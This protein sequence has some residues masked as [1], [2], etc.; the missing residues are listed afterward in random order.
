MI[1]LAV[2]MAEIGQ[3][4]PHA[5]LPDMTRCTVR[6]EYNTG[7]FEVTIDYPIA[8]DNAEMIANGNALIIDTPGRSTAQLF[9]IS[10]V[11]RPVSGV[12]S[13]TAQHISY[14][15]SSVMCKPFL[16]G[17][18]HWPAAVA[19]QKCLTAAV[20]PIPYAQISCDITDTTLADVGIHATVPTSL[21]KIL[22]D[23]IAPAF[24]AEIK[25]DNVNITVTKEQHRQSGAV[26]AY[27]KNIVSGS[28]DAETAKIESGI[29]AYYGDAADSAKGYVD[30]GAVID[31]ELGLPY[32]IISVDLTKNFESLPNTKQLIAAAN[33]YKARRIA[34]IAPASL[35]IDFVPDGTIILPGDI[36]KVKLY[37]A[38]AEDRIVTATTYDALSRRVTSV[39]FGNQA[40]NDL[41]KIIASLR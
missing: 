6:E 38:A 34:E 21:R 11:S 37:G 40:Q 13:A 33:A 18:Q 15:Y 17:G 2:P 30:T 31:Y 20:N 7:V 3:Y 29:F 14:L 36:A 25:V 23:Q 12:I 19:L 10:R 8:G 22:Y 1:L 32:N 41:A 24:G 27:A 35:K 9:V 4:A 28:T 5:T 16:N 26:L 39:E